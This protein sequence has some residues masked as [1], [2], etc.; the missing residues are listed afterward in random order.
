MELSSYVNIPISID[1]LKKWY[2]ETC[3]ID[4]SDCPINGRTCE[5]MVRIYE[6]TINEE[7]I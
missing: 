3:K 4:C 5:I 7:E 1:F 6:T 2:E